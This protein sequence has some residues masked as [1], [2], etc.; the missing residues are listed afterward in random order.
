MTIGNYT[1]K[2][3]FEYIQD[4]PNQGANSTTFLARD[5]QLNSILVFKQVKID[6]INP[7]NYFNEANIIYENRHL[8]IVSVNYGCYDDDY[9]YV[10]MPYYKN[11][12]IKDKI[13]KGN[14]LSPR[15]VI[16][17]SIHFL[18]GLNHIHS[19]GL[20]HFDIKPD[21]IMISDSDEALVADFGLAK[22]MIGGVADPEKLYGLHITPEFITGNMSDFRSD[23]FQAGL[24]IYRMLNGYSSLSDQAAGKTQN[25]IVKGTFPDRSKY[26]PHIP[27]AL[28]KIVNKCISVNPT[29]RY[30][31]VLE[32]INDLSNIPDS[33]LLDWKYSQNGTN[34]I[35]CRT[36]SADI[37]YVINIENTI[38][39]SI[40]TSKYISGRKQ[41]MNKYCFKDISKIDKDKKIKEILT[42]L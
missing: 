23:I 1:K 26:L 28:K 10:V 11:G 6:K 13:I 42:S 24:T 38:K 33:P 7:V 36:K 19:K 25:D 5:N 29:S 20:I 15:E 32:I 12:T 30:N 16:R 37:K 41:N 3:D 39:Y 21:N 2:L 40:F 17:Y 22:H 27:V 35:F 18:T 31:N 8:Y 14:S 34:E 4:L 9:I